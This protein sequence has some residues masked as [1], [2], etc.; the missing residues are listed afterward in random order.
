MTNLLSKSQN[1][2]LKLL[3][4]LYKYESVPQKLILKNLN[5]NEKTLLSDIQSINESVAPIAIHNKPYLGV[6]LIIPNNYN[7]DYIYRCFL[8]TSNEYALIETIFLDESHSLSSV[9]DYLYLSMS[10]IRRLILRINTQLEESGIGI[11]SQ[12]LSLV[13]SEEKIY[14]FMV[15]YLI[16][17]FSPTDSF[18]YSPKFACI[19]EIIHIMAEKNGVSLNFPDLHRVKIWIYTFLIRLANGHFPA[20]PQ[21]IP[22]QFD[23]SITTNISIVN[24]FKVHFKLPLNKEIISYMFQFLLIEDYA[25][26]FSMLK[27][28]ATKNNHINYKLNVIEHTIKRLS[29]EF[30]LPLENK[31]TLILEMYNTTLLMLIGNT[32]I[33]NNQHKIFVDSITRNN[34][35]FL[36]I[37]NTELTKL[38][39]SKKMEESQMYYLAYCLTTHWPQLYLKLQSIQKKV[40]IGLFFYTDSEHTE[41]IKDEL[42]YYFRDKINIDLMPELSLK[43]FK[44][45]APNY[46][47]VITNIYGLEIENVSVVSFP[48]SPSIRDYKI[49]EEIIEKKVDKVN[50][51]IGH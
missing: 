20:K 16:E 47:I 10:T 6:Q 43:E 34:R 4:Y 45:N 27:L 49:I 5:Y 17:R 2:Q 39:V 33:L 15:S 32:F 30:S 28:L 18:F 44:H 3:E 48:F 36:Y 8:S 35:A 46:D 19:E 9:S 7:F 50:N 41:Y 12:P 37:L 13:G 42:T 40:H 21:D 29:E 11:S 1:R 24:T 14:G 22:K 25:L 51:F 23:T 31:E 26:N 38:F